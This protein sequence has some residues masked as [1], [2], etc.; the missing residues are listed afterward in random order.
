MTVQKDPMSLT[1][2]FWDGLFAKRRK[3]AFFLGQVWYI[4]YLIALTAMSF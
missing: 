1:I 4:L 3:G 2:G